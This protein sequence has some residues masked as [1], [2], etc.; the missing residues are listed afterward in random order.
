MVNT[1]K[2]LVWL[3]RTGD[4]EAFSQLV[5][6]FQSKVYRAAYALT[7]N[8]HD[9]KD[10]SQETF[11]RAFRGLVRFRAKSSFFTW[12]YRILL[13]VFK[14]SVKSRSREVELLETPGE[15]AGASGVIS[16]AT[17]SSE[18][19]ALRENVD[20]AYRAI[21]SLPPEQRMAIVLH[22]LE[23]MTY[24]QIA[25]AMGCSIG[26]VKSRIHGARVALKRELLPRNL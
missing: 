23:S 14:S 10:L 7:G 21:Y 25:K 8:E 18:M 15:G 1:E 2:Q 3:A 6:L 11:I 13:N 20:H 26:T 16:R 22:A 12:L 5:L 17:G 24:R 4:K 9:A 19:A